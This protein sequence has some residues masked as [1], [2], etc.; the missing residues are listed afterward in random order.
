M[1]ETFDPY[2]TWLGIPPEEQDRLFG[3]FR[4][5]SVRPTGGESSTGLGL[6]IAKKVVD[7]HSGRIFLESVVGSGSTF[8]VSLPVQARDAGTA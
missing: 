1:S 8:T 2:Y 4:R 7:A 6:A 3:M 5:T